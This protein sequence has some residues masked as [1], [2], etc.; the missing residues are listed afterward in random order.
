MRCCGS[1]SR[2]RRSTRTDLDPPLAG[3]HSH[4]PGAPEQRAISAPGR[5]RNRAAV[6]RSRDERDA[7]GA[8][9]RV[10]R[11]RD[12]WDVDP[13]R[14]SFTER[15]KCPRAPRRSSASA[16]GPVPRGLRA[17]LP[18]RPRLCRRLR[19][20]GD[21]KGASAVVRCPWRVG[22]R[23][24]AAPSFA[25][26]KNFTCSQARTQKKEE[27]PPTQSSPSPFFTKNRGS[28]LLSHPTTGQYHQRK[29]T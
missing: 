8:L 24:C 3:D 11:L 19:P 7:P 20:V 28:N 14:R 9:V 21:R 4:I 23:R 12:A 15:V 10:P 27:K 26:E 29:E 17:T 1:S 22:S 18:E 5:V 16:T 6:P 2:T 13:P 25:P